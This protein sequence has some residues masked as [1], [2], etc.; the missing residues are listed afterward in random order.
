[1][2]SLAQHCFRG[3]VRYEIIV[4]ISGRNGWDDQFG[5]AH[6]LPLAYFDASKNFI[7]PENST[8]AT[9]VVTRLAKRQPDALL[10]IFTELG[11]AIAPRVNR[12]AIQRRSAEA[13]LAA[14]LFDFDFLVH[15]TLGELSAAFY[16]DT[17]DAWQ[18]NS[19]YWSQVGFLNL[20]RYNADPTSLA[21]KEALN[22][23]VQHARH[24][25]A[26]E[27][28]PVPLT[29]LGRILFSQVLD[30]RP[31]LPTA[32]NE[33]LSYLSEAISRERSMLRASVHP[34]I[35]LFRGTRDYLEAGGVATGE[36]AEQLR[37]FIREARSKFPY[38]AE[39]I[40]AVQRLAPL[41]GMGIN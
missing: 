5:S 29:A 24:A 7:I 18:W 9:Q 38:D 15:P 1:V 28:H 20:A 33:A 36:Q 26:V 14:R 11:N 4:A 6:P 34:F 17:Q 8:L 13:R 3:G 19:R 21:G 10:K 27:R 32:Y 37:V 25:V 35:T 31:V 39:L 23:A 2:A 30:E 12:R 40:E 41:L 16:A 22:H